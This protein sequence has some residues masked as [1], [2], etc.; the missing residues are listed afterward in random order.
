MKARP[1][2]SAH[3]AESRLGSAAGATG[4]LRTSSATRPEA[5]RGQSAAGSSNTSSGG[6]SAGAAGAAA[7]CPA[8]SMERFEFPTDE[9][10]GNAT[11]T[12]DS[13]WVPVTQWQ[14][15]PV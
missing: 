5:A 4:N 1:S 8:S 15:V 2:G 12:D 7:A 9:A 10:A 13:R 14:S 11:R 3:K 6:G